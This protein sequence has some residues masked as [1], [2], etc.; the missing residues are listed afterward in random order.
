M[1]YVT[2]KY[3]L[4][5]NNVVKAS[6]RLLVLVHPCHVSRPGVGCVVMLHDGLDH[7][8]P[9]TVADSVEPNAWSSSLVH[10]FPCV[11][12][13]HVLYCTVLYCTVLYCTAMCTVL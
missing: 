8:A 12:Y 2:V 3:E 1:P 7:L 11:L 9:T 6:A 5:Y 10:V 13:C 4:L